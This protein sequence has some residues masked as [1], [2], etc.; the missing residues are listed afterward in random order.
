MSSPGTPVS[1]QWCVNRPW[2]D[3]A[4]DCEGRQARSGCDWSRRFIAAPQ[5][6]EAPA[7]INP[8]LGRAMP[9][10]GRTSALGE[11]PARDWQIYKSRGSQGAAADLVGRLPS[12]SAAQTFLTD[13]TPSLREQECCN[14]SVSQCPVGG[15]TAMQPA[16]DQWSPNRKG[17]P[18]ITT[19]WPEEGGLSRKG[20]LGLRLAEAPHP[21]DVPPPR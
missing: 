8:S 9:P 13:G 6:A 18:P 1:G 20:G 10:T 15:A 4:I 11:G 7:A 3:E 19:A 16:S 21:C 2:S 17:K 12:W 5:W 14:E